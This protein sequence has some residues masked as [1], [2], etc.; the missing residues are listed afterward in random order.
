MFSTRVL[1]ETISHYRI[2]RKRGGGGMLSRFGG[3]R[4]ARRN[5]P[6]AEAS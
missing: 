1:G 5:P 6:Q 3:V 2:L 4:A